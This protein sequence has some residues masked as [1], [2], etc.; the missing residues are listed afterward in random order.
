MSEVRESWQRNSEVGHVKSGHGFFR[1]QF[2]SGESGSV[3]S[4]DYT[5]NLNGV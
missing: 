2:G 5:E 3:Q 4:T 1:E